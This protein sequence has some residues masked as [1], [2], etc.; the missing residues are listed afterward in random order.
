MSSRR[1]LPQRSPS[2]VLDDVDWQDKRVRAGI[3]TILV[4]AAVAVLGAGIDESGGGSRS[5]LAGDSF[6]AAPSLTLSAPVVVTST[7]AP[8]APPTTRPPEPQALV[9]TTA[10]VP[11][12]ARPTTPPTTAI[13]IDGSVAASCTITSAVR[14]GSTGDAVRCVQRRLRQVMSVDLG[15]DV[16]GRFG[17][18]TETAVR[19]FQQASGLSVDGVVGATTARALGI[20][21][22]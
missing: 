10:F 17:P 7:V 20:W 12:T 4:V 19:R 14:P 21:G 22:D 9:A 15:S 16:D 3:S 1:R 18:G 8:P 6:L 13:T 11:T 2:D 5:A